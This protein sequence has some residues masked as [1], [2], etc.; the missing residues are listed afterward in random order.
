MLRIGVVG[1]SGAVGQEMLDVLEHRGLPVGELRA[2]ASPRSTGQSVVF[3]GERLPLATC[4]E[5]CFRGLD[6]VLFSAGAERSRLFAPQAVREG[7]LVV[8]NSS[9]FR[10]DPRVPL[11]VPEVNPEALWGHEGLVANPNCST[12]QMV[13]ALEPARQ[14]FGLRRVVVATYQSVSGAGRRST[15]ELE[16]AS[17]AVLEGSDEPRQVYPRGIAFEVV[18]EIDVFAEQGWTKEE[19]KM[20]QETRKI[21]GAPALPVV[22]T[23][24]RVPVFRCHSEAVFVETIEPVDL[25]ALRRR[26]RSQAGLQLHEGD[27]DYPL[28]R[29]MAGR[30]EVAVGR[31]RLVPE[32][33]RGLAFWVVADNLRKGAATNAVQIVE[34][35][36]QAG[37]RSASPP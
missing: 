2:F 5:G 9:A 28:A 8:D 26:M 14:L 18:P 25:E 36:W 32:D 29:E 12:I 4:R 33:P 21:L 31:L 13:L 30:D 3:R 19:T 27:G 34:K 23:C 7:A 16:T 17:R 1:A 22:A 24:V 37:A 10:M 11:V 6:F 15:A 20:R 35:L